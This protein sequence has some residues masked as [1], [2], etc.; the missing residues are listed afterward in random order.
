[1]PWQKKAVRDLGYILPHGKGFRVMLTMHGKLFAGPTRA[2][3]G[4]ADWDLRWVRRCGSREQM[5]N[6]IKL[7]H[8]GHTRE[9]LRGYEKIL[10]M[11]SL[12]QCAAV[13]MAA[14]GRT[15]FAISNPF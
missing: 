14:K 8:N 12:K 10:H 5:C 13:L 15:V 1:M 9:H 3:H 11:S 7:L 6:F 4:L 2:S